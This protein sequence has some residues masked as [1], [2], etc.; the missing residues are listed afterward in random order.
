MQSYTSIRELV[1]ELNPAAQ[2]SNGSLAISDARAFREQM[3]DRLVYSAVFGGDDVKAASRWLIWQ[4]GQ[5]LGAVSASINDYYLAG[6]RGEWA[7]RTT[8]AI[9]IRGMAYDMGRAVFRTA[10]KNNCKQVIVEIARSEMGYTSQRPEEYATVALAAAMREGYRGPVFIQ[11]DHFQINAKNY[12]KDAQKEVQGVKDLIVEALAAGFYNI[13]IDSSTVVDLSQPTESE[14]Q[15]R[16]Y[17]HTAELTAYIRERE[18]KGTTVSVGGEIG[19]VGGK[20]STVSELEAFMEGYL[21]QLG[22]QGGQRTGISKI[23]VQTGTSHGGVVLPDG[24]IAQIKVDFD[25][26][27]KLSEV[28]REKYGL[29]GAVQHGASTLPEEAFNRFS[30]ANACEVHLAT[31]FQNIIYD[32]QAFP[33]DLRDE[34]YA[35][36]A[37]N[38]ADERKPE[39]TE[40]QFYYTTRK[41]GFGPFKQQFWDLPGD[42]RQ[43]ICQELEE[44]FDLIF[45]RLNVVNTAALVDRFVQPSKNGKPVPEALKGAGVSGS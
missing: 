19:E 18:P 23:S 12:A 35:H 9:N 15:Q 28:A 44:R 25:T 41:R 20:N 7:N 6:G 38:H 37:Q 27:G 39:M 40:A 4:A 32:S 42:V 16:N 22:A 33:K 1:N 5:E 36:L 31:G 2:L 10:L 45:Q 13:D 21:K 3:L 26:L 30:E 43:Q 14:Q 8:P 24:T 17:T 34:I 11:G 29:G